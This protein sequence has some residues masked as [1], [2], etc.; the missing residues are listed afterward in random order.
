MK[1]YEELKGDAGF[2][3]V[4]LSESQAKNDLARK[5]RLKFTSRFFRQADN[6][7]VQSFPSHPVRLEREKVSCSPLSTSLPVFS[8]LFKRRISSIKKMSC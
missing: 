4:K 6:L 7:D 2:K 3:P 5:S 8:R 1:S